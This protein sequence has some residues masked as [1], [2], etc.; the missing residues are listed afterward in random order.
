MCGYSCLCHHRNPYN[1]NFVNQH[2]AK[3]VTLQ[4]VIKA[5]TEFILRQQEGKAQHHTYR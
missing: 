1:S 4:K 3:Q 2:R 5:P